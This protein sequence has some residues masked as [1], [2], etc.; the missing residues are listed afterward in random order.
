LNSLKYSRDLAPSDYSYILSPTLLKFSSQY[1]E[2]Q[3]YTGRLL[4]PL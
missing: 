3:V 1:L 4:P 2:V